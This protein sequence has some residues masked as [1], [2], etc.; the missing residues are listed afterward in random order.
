MKISRQEYWSGGAHFP[1][2]EDLPTPGIESV[3]RVSPALQADSLPAVPSGKP[4]SIN[5][6]SAK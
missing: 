1:S 4:S 5:E 6:A 3:S 2:P